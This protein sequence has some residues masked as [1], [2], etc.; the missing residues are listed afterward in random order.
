MQKTPRRTRNKGSREIWYLICELVGK[1]YL[2]RV[3]I[4]PITP[5]LLPSGGLSRRLTRSPSVSHAPPARPRPGQEHHRGPGGSWPGSWPTPRLPL[6]CSAGLSS[7][8]CQ[9]TPRQASSSP[10]G[11]PRSV[12]LC[13][14]WLGFDC[15]PRRSRQGQRWAISSSW[16]CYQ[17]RRSALA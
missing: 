8:G 7:A 16:Q 17:G 3:F 5:P 11:R 6:Q 12:P 2:Y 1:K 13:V 14:T 4:A 15:S 9:Q 10:G